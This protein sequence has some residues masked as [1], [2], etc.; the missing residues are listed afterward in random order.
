[1]DFKKLPRMQLAKDRENIK[2]RGKDMEDKK[3]ITSNQ[4]F[5]MRR[6]KNKGKRTV[7]VRTTKNLP[8]LIKVTN[9]K[10]QQTG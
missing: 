7:K 8:C 6:E 10:I 4:T 1:M 3:A 5:K 9:P 2:E